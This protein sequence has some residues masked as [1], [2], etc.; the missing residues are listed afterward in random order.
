MPVKTNKLTT[1]QGVSTHQAHT[2]VFSI[3][4]SLSSVTL[5]SKIDL[6]NIRI[7][8][9]YRVWLSKQ[10]ETKPAIC[11]ALN[12]YKILETDTYFF[13]TSSVPY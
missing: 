9:V 6:I 4:L 11:Q 12:Q 7:S 5:E 8:F 13:F 10:W 2:Q 1:R 3:D